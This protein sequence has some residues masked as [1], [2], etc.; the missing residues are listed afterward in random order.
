MRSEPQVESKGA[1]H[2]LKGVYML[3]KI[4]WN[5]LCFWTSIGA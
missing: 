1:S 2:L 4:M 5:R 3:N